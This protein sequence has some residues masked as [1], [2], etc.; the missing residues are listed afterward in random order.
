MSLAVG[1]QC[2]RIRA[3]SRRSEVMHQGLARIAVVSD[4]YKILIQQNTE[5]TE[6]ARMLMERATC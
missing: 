6:Q 3:R 4:Q 5:L 1:G 2:P